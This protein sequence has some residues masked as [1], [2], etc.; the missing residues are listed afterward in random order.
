MSASLLVSSLSAY[1]ADFELANIFS[2]MSQFLKI[3][4]S[5][6]VSVSL[7]PV[8]LENPDIILQ[9]YFNSFANL[10]PQQR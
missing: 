3:S 2:Y 10:W 6:S 9:G 4:L 5:L 1:S 8:L 7:S